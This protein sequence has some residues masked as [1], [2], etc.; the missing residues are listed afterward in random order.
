[1]RIA[2]AVIHKQLMSDSLKMKTPPDR[3]CS[4]VWLKTGESNLVL[5]AIVLTRCP[6]CER[7]DYALC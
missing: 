4:G 7:R 2:E 3:V 5:A 1:M 6:F